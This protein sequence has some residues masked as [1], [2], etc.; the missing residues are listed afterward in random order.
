MLHYGW[1]RRNPH[2][3]LSERSPRSNQCGGC[4]YQQTSLHCEFPFHFDDFLSS[5]VGRGV[6]IY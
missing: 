1:G 5:C 6:R 4:P 2:Y 3:R